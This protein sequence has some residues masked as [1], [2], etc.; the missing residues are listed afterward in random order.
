MRSDLSKGLRASCARRVR[1]RSL[2]ND[3]PYKWQEYSSSKRII[4]LVHHDNR[5]PFITFYLLETG[6]LAMFARG[7]GNESWMAAKTLW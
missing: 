3:L 7:L 1:E 2:A 4:K 5:G 6:D